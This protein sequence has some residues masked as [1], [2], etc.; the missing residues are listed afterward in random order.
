MRVVRDALADTRQ[1][2]A[3]PMWTLE[4]TPR[5]FGFAVLLASVLGHRSTRL[6]G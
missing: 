2:V 5:D 1:I 6:S 3:D 4:W